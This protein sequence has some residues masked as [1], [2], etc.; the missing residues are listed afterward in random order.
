[1]NYV[2]PLLKAKQMLIRKILKVVL[3]SQKMFDSLE[4]AKDNR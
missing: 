1:M 3:V 2:L 4:L